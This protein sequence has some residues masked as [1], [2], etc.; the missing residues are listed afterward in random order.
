MALNLEFEIEGNQFFV[1]VEEDEIFVQTESEQ[2]IKINEDVLLNEL[3]NE[4][5]DWENYDIGYDNIELTN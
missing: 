4:G 2:V 1:A 3:G 5:I